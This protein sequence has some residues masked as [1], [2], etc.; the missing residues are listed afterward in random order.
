MD[1][2]VLATMTPTP[3]IYGDFK[4]FE[5]LTCMSVCMAV[6]PVCIVLC[7]TTEFKMDHDL[8][9][10]SYLTSPFVLL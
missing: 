9:H 8:Q 5:L 4:Q 1:Q 7:Q 6:R 2:D 3:R 10:S